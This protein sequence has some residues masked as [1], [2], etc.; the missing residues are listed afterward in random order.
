MF[1]FEIIILL[2]LLII[3]LLLMPIVLFIDTN[4]KQ[5]YLQFKGLAKASIESDNQE[6]L[7]LKLELFFFKFYFYPLKYIW[8]KNKRDIKKK[9]NKTREIGIGGRNLYK[10]IKS[11][12]VKKFLLNIDTG[13]CIWNAKLYPLFSLL[14]YYWGD[15]NINFEGRNHMVLHIQ[16][17]PLN[18][19]KSFIN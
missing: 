8:S 2:V 18:I 15:F 14:N 6:V 11:F 16:N 19:I 10:I 3:Y 17:R 4:N 12:K 9:T 7:R 5:Y 1:L 13:D